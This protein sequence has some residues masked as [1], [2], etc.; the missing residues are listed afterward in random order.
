M[1]MRYAGV[2]VTLL[3]GAA[4]VAEEGERAAA[5]PLSSLIDSEFFTQT[6]W[7]DGLAEVATYDAVVVIDG[8]DCEHTASL[9]TVGEEYTTEFYTRA[10][11]PHGQKPILS[12]MR[13]HHAAHVETPTFPYMFAGDVVV[14]RE[15]PHRPVRLVTSAGGWHGI[16]QKDFQLWRDRPLQ[17]WTSFRDGE[18]SGERLLRRETEA[19][20]EEELPLLLRALRFEDGLQGSLRL[21]PAQLTSTAAEPRAAAALLTVTAQ[22]GQWLALLE[23]SDQRAMEFEFDLERP[24][25]LRRFSHSDGRTMELKSVERTDYLQPRGEE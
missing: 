10:N 16:M 22:E 9:V 23:T 5:L 6:P 18:G 14:E 25:V 13:Q 11:W 7:T 24:H 17:R 2:L 21:H 12:V 1:K 19:Y 15:L 4:A 8:E 20:F 3:A